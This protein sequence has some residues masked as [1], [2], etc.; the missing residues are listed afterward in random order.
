MTQDHHDRLNRARTAAGEA[1]ID[2]LLI[3]PGAA[4][5]YLTGYDALPLERLTCLIVPSHGPVSLV[6][7]ALE[8]PAARA[9]VPEGLTVTAWPETDDPV[10]VV[11]AQLRDRKSTRLNSS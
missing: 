10:D 1:G 8:E 7:P 9:S 11:A 4:L 6:V 2:A 5:R 3:T